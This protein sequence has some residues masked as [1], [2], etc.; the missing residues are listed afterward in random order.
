MRL[1]INK[2]LLLVKRSLKWSIGVFLLY[3]FLQYN[4]YHI[5]ESLYVY[6]FNAAVFIL[7][8]GPLFCVLSK[9]LAK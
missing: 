5:F 2:Y 3:S 4:R 6:G 1:Y 9:K 8:A 7:V